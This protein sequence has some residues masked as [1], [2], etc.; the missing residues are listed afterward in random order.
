[1]KADLVSIKE[2]IAINKLEKVT[3]PIIFGKGAV[4]TPDGLLS[5]EIFGVTSTDRKET[6][7]YIDLHGYFFHPKTYKE[8]KR[9]DRRFESIV[10][11]TKKYIITEDGGLRLDE[12]NGETG[13]DFLYRNWE[14]IKFKRN[15]SNARNERINFIEAYDKNHHFTR[16]WLVM[17]AFYRDVN[18]KNYSGG[19]ISHNELTD[20]YSKLLKYANLL[21]TTDF[22]FMMYNTQFTVQQT[23]VDIYNFIKSKQ[24]KKGGN[25]RRNLLGKSIDYGARA[26]ISAPQFDYSQKILISFKYSGIPLPQLCSLF[27][28]FL[29]YYLKRWIQDKQTELNGYYEGKKV[30]DLNMYYNET[31]LKKQIDKFV[32]SYSDRF[33]RVLIPFVNESE[34]RQYFKF[35]GEDKEGNKIERDLT[36][37]DLIYQSLYEATLDKHVW[38]SRYPILD[39]F[40]TFPSRISVMS[41]KKTVYMKTNGKVYEAYPNID[42]SFDKTTVSTYF[43]DTVVMS[44]VYLKGLGGDY[45]IP[46]CSL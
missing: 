11:G 8:L 12:E 36:W 22:D 1:M 9:L 21:E 15:E 19:Q 44:N 24:E 3:N 43:L 41:T 28:P 37:C 35:E 18:F 33:E 23:L 14:K 7:A 4:P 30:P 46:S 27:F 45:K 38:I 31:I 2:V 42:I 13:L 6:F 10:A 16:Y 39:Y 20:K 5:T 26:V 40:G 29:Q 32:F 17:P 25:I 34:P